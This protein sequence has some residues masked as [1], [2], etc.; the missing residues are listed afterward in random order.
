MTGA[1]KL[2]EAEMNKYVKKK[3]SFMTNLK[4]IIPSILGVILFMFPIKVVDKVTI[5]I[6][7]LSDFIQDKCGNYLPLIVLCLAGFSFLGCLTTALLFHFGKGNVVEKLKKNTVF[8]SIFQVSFFSLL[9]RGFAFALCIFTYYELGTDMIYSMNTGGLVFYDLLPILFTIFFLAGFL[10]PLLLNFGLLE[11][12]GTL[13]IK[14]MRPLFKLPGRAAIDAIASWLG[15]GTIGVLLTSKQYEEGFYT[16]REA[17]VIGT[18][19]S[20][21]SITFCLVVINTVGLSHMFV[22]FYL[23]VSFACLVAAI[24]IPKLPPLSRKKDCFIDGVKASD[25]DEEGSSLLMED[26]KAKKSVVV[27]Y[28]KALNKVEDKKVVKSIVKDGVSNVLNMWLVVI[29]IVMAMGTTA[30]IIAEYTPLFEILGKPFLPFLKMLGIPEAAAVSKT[31]FA[32]FADMLLPSV[33]I[34]NVGNDMTRFIVAAVSVTQLIYL[35]EVGALLIASKIP[36]KLGELFI[37]FIE[38]TLITLPI[39][40]LIAHL[41]F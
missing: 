24:L 8:C 12:A 26:G 23:S 13:L 18:S 2:K 25:R 17:C 38:R 32:G 1:E 6:A 20:L 39:I 37:I 11:F 29:P 7:V 3:Y 4:F 28:H 34:S 16:E 36:V 5:P 14:I 10:L 41:L 40:T 27:A 30:L 9:V 22:P 35:S 19:F 33:M 15:D 21:V 31:L